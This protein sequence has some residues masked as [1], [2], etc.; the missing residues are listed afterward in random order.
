[1][2]TSGSDVHRHLPNWYINL[3]A[4]QWE[5]EAVLFWS[6]AWCGVTRRP[7]SV[8]A[9][10]IYSARLIFNY[11]HF[12]STKQRFPVYLRHIVS[13]ADNPYQTRVLKA[14]SPDYY[15]YNVIPGPCH[16]QRV[17]MGAF[18]IAGNNFQSN[19]RILEV[20]QKQHSFIHGVI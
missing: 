4:N 16:F 7:K 2:H 14:F 18:L 17:L 19:A 1:M 8:T 12:S 20:C 15:S 13:R 6:W 3:T 11:P 10:K 9:G 5:E